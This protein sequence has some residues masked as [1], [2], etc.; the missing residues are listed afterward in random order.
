MTAYTVSLW[1]NAS[2]SEVTGYNVY[3]SS[4]VNGTYAKINSALDANTAYTDST[5]A[6]DRLTVTKPPR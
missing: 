5:V 1:W 4:T 6:L 2:T 3:R